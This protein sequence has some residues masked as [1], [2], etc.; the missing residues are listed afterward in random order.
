MWWQV[1]MLVTK[2]YKSTTFTSTRH[3]VH[4]GLGLTSFPRVWKRGSDERLLLSS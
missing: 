3:V 2:G 1:A 4:E